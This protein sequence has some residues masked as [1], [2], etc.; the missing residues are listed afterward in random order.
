VNAATQNDGYP[1][2][3]IGVRTPVALVL[4]T[5]RAIVVAVSVEAR[6]VVRL[7][8]LSAVTMTAIVPVVIALPIA[9]VVMRPV[10]LV[11]LIVTY[12]PAFPVIGQGQGAAAQ[13]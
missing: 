9:P 3:L 4:M 2:A 7:P 5:I 10:A 8:V 12:I 6:T 11:P 1:I 13:D